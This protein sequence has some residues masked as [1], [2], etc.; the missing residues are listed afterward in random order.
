MYSLRTQNN[1]AQFK[2]YTFRAYCVSGI[3]LGIGVERLIK[4]DRSETSSCQGNGE[5]VVKGNYREAGAS[6]CRQQIRLLSTAVMVSWVHTYV[7]T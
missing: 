1:S 5:K 3:G 6:F 4:Y 7:R 2:K